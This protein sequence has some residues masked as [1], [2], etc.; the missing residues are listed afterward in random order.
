MWSDWSSQPVVELANGI[1]LDTNYYYWPGW[2]VE[3]RPGLFTGS[4][5]PMRFATESGSMID[6]YQA[7]TQ[8]TDESGQTYPA[9]ID[10]L[11]DN[12]LGPLGYYG[13]FTANMHTDFATSSQSDAVV[14]A[15]LARGVP[16]VSARQLLT[17]VDA[18]NDSAFGPITWSGSTL[19]FSVTAGANATGLQV[20]VPV[21]AGGLRLSGITLTGAP[22][23]YTTQTIKGIEYAFVTVAAGQ[24]A[25]T[26]V[27]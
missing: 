26:Y 1:R 25:A 8:M 23:A 17:W 12:A 4:G 20:M 9:T 19:T 3:D 22:V 15:A 5:M 14:G 2:W 16:V 18:R 27:P 7:A 24:Y 10:A 11:L 13:A 21:D 6:V